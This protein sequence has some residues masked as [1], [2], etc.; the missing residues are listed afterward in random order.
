MVKQRLAKL[1]LAAGN[2]GGAWCCPWCGA[3]RGGRGQAPLVIFSDDPSDRTPYGPDD[4]CPR[5]C[6]AAPEAVVIPAALL[7]GAASP[8]SHKGADHST[9]VSHAATALEQA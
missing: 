6:A 8:S 4:C 3:P 5:C 2:L 7:T 1:Q 9:R